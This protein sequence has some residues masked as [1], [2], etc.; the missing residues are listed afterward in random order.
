[1][2]IDVCPM[3][4]QTLGITSVPT[5]A[6]Y[7]NGTQ[8]TK[9]SGANIQKLA[10]LVAEHAGAGGAA[11]E[12]GGGAAAAGAGAGAAEV[13]PGH[14]DLGGLIDK[15]SVACLNQSDAHTVCRRAGRPSG[16]SRAQ[17]KLLLRRRGYRWARS[18]PAI[19]AHS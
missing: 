11:A 2:D 14:V 19:R 10:A 5:F 1:M 18:S 15:S 3:V 17:K 9:F 16:A 7:R 8:V 4:A 13:V 12:A 6:L